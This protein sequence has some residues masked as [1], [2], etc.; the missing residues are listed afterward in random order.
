GIEVLAQLRML[1]HQGIHSLAD[2]GT[3]DVDGSLLAHILAQRR[4]NMDLAHIFTVR[5]AA[6]LRQDSG[7]RARDG[8]GA[9]DSGRRGEDPAD[10]ASAAPRS[11]TRLT[12]HFC[13]QC[14]CSYNL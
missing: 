13:H 9:K 12:S 3:V 5:D 1:R 10:E 2:G 6:D 8:P 14:S 11:E 7:L 4:R